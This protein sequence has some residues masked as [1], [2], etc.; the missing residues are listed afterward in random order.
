MRQWT[1]FAVFVGVLVVVHPSAGQQPKAT[2]ARITISGA[3][4]GT[5]TVNTDGVKER[6]VLLE[7][8]TKTTV[9]VE[10]NQDVDK[11]T[12]LRLAEHRKLFADFGALAKKLAAKGDV[13]GL[14]KAEKE[15][16]AANDEMLKYLSYYAADGTLK[17]VKDEL[18]LAGKLRLFDYKGADKALGKGKTLVEG[19]ATQVMF[20]AGQGAKLT[21][22][23]KNE[24]NPI[25]L[26]GKLAQDMA[27]VKGL[28]RAQGVLRLD[29]TSIVVEVEALEAVK[30]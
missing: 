12:E 3:E 23:I 14:K 7:M 16:D 15:F 4:V 28:I 25:V 27:N 21:L 29:K 5:V 2:P 6:F 30:K 19:E 11:F 24:D 13:E 20:D 22:A 9:K 10:T 26:T 17:V 8:N 1:T 18:R